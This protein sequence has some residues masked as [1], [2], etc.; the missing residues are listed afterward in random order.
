MAEMNATAKKIGCEN[1]S[2]ANVTGIDH[3]NQYTTARDI[4]RI[5]RYAIDFPEFEPL[6]SASQYTAT[7]VS[8]G[9]GDR[10]LPAPTT[11]SGSPPN[12]TY[13]PLAFRITGYTDSAGAVASPRSR[14]TADMSISWW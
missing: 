7:P 11:Y 9:E 13:E 6:F 1:T 5:M 8:G 14:G 12:I 3:I 10:S 2:F 4:Y